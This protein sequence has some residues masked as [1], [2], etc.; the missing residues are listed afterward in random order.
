MPGVSPGGVGGYQAD[1]GEEMSNEI[2]EQHG[3]T[4]TPSSLE[5][6]M[7]FSEIISKSDLVPKDYK[8]KPGNVLVAIQM[9]QEIGLPPMQALQ[10]IAVINGRPS[11]W[12]D[13]IP[14]II[15][16]HPHYEWMKESFDEKTMTATCVIKRRGDHEV[17]GVFSQADAQ[18][19]GLWKKQGPW[20]QYPRRML[21]MRA[22]SFAARD[23]FP[24]ALKGL[25]VAEEVQDVPQVK[26][27]TPQQPETQPAALEQQE[28][29]TLDHAV[30][31]IE[32]CATEEELREEAA[33]LCAALDGATQAK[34]RDVYKAKLAELKQ[35]A[36]A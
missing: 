25:S 10:N 5:E 9:G 18:A 13:A 36:Q 2:T 23:A 20:T 16:S 21:Q 33:P 11:V 4:L 17:V 35:E 8:N 6:A 30:F 22:R 1:E 34:A 24:D 12:G 32:G 31:V 26:D 28:T 19:A 14:A 15:K 7:K 3:F 29:I 27:V